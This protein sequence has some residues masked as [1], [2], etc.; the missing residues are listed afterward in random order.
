MRNRPTGSAAQEGEPERRAW[1]QEDLRGPGGCRGSGW[2][3]QVP[4]DRV[5][6]FAGAVS[7]G[8]RQTWGTSLSGHRGPSIW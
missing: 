1:G 2:G 6:G 7:G 3:E 5:P 4:L 8:S